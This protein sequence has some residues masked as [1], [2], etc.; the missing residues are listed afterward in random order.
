[1]PTQNHELRQPPRG[2]ENWDRDWYYNFDAVDELAEI[3]DAEENRTDYTAFTGAKYLSTDTQNVFLGTGSGWRKLESFGRNPDFGSVTADSVSVESA[4]D[5]GN[6]VVR[7]RDIDEMDLGGGGGASAGIGGEHTEVADGTTT[8]FRWDTGIDVTETEIDWITVD[9]TTE[10]A[11][12]DFSRRVVGSEIVLT[13]YETPNADTQMGWYW[14]ATTADGS[15]GGGSGTSATKYGSYITAT[16][17]SSALPDSIQ[18]A[19]LTEDAD[20]HDPKTH[21]HTGEVLSPDSVDAQSASVASEPVEATDVVRKQEIDGLGSGGIGGEYSTTGDGATTIFTWD[22]G[23]SDP[24]DIQYVSI[25]A[26]SEPATTDFRSFID[27]TSI[28]VEYAKP[29]SDGEVLSW[30]WSVNA[31][32]MSVSVESHDHNGDTLTPATVTTGGLDASGPVTLGGVRFWIQPTEPTD[33][34]P[35]DV[36]IETDA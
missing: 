15:T 36:W 5:L 16:D 8:E 32:V 33:A 11:S 29:P 22:T 23:V 31:S 24:A 9:P 6:E 4:P 20:L 30:F 3:R 34:A 14:R 13:Y 17:E 26:T 27:G 2:Q 19:S 10:G 18:H 7:L 28:G 12:T 21:D 1:M 35:D 25:D